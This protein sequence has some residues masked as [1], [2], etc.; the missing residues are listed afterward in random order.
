MFLQACVCP[1]GGGACLSACWDTTTP[2]SSRHPPRED[3]PTQEQTPPQEKTPPK[4][5]HPQEQT[6]PGADT[7]PRA[8]TAPLPP[9]TAVVADGTHPTGMHSCL[10]LWWFTN[11]STPG[12]DNHIQWRIPDFREVGAPTYDFAKFFQKL[13]EIKRIWTPSTSLAGGFRSNNQC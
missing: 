11:K 12:S 6:P 8:D 4:S 5:R 2:G 1:Q 10:I 13:H 9:E 3:T 7:S